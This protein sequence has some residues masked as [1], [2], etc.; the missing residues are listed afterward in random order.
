LSTAPPATS[1]LHYQIVRALLSTCRCP[2]NDELQDALGVTNVAL[3]QAFRE[4]EAAHAIVLHPG[5]LA[6]WVI[7]PFSVTPTATWVEAG[8]RGWWAP[9]IWCAFG[10]ATLAGGEVS[11]HSRFGGES[12]P[13]TIPVWDGHPV[14]A[15]GCCVHFAMRPAEAWNNVHAYC[16]TVLP[17][18]TQADVLDWSTRHGLPLGEVIPL[19]RTADLGRRWYGRHAELQ[20]QKWT[21]AEAQAIF[22]AAGLT[23]EFWN[24]GT[25]RGRF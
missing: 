19:Q 23:S 20:W 15:A 2:S 5:T 18:R 3:E 13:V 14:A 1:Q 22:D 21:V 16:A 17:F 9:C 12:D 8:K 25:Q 11:I 7:H 24:L 6:P 10:I 4:L